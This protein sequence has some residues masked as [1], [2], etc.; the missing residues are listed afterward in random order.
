[1]TLKNDVL[2]GIAGHLDGRGEKYELQVGQSYEKIQVSPKVGRW[3]LVVEIDS[4][5]GN[6]RVSRLDRE[7]EWVSPPSVVL[8]PTDSRF[9]DILDKMLDNDPSQPWGEE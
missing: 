3:E 9:F 8:D 7:G 1:M 4:K 2:K 5:T 6:V